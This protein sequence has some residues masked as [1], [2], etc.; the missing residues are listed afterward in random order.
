MTQGKN[1]RAKTKKEG[2]RA[3]GSDPAASLLRAGLGVL[4]RREFQGKPGEKSQEVRKVSRPDNVQK[5]E[6]PSLSVLIVY[7][8][9]HDHST[10]VYFLYSHLLNAI[11]ETGGMKMT[12]KLDNH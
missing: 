6:L 3:R 4:A 7:T 1:K 12:R 10:E 11:T 9:A 2:D 8:Q 5:I